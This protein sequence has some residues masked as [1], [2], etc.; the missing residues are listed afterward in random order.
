MF[1]V[2]FV[3]ILL[4]LR[5]LH[6]TKPIILTRRKLP[7]TQ[8]RQESNR[9]DTSLFEQGK[10]IKYFVAEERSGRNRTLFLPPYP[11]PTENERKNKEK[12]KKHNVPPRLRPPQSLCHWHA[13][14]LR[15]CFL[16]ESSAFLT[17]E[18]IDALSPRGMLE[19][20]DRF[21][22]GQTDAKKAVAISLR[23]RWR[24]RQITDKGLQ[25]DIMPKN[26]LMIGPTGV[27][28]TEIS[29]RMA[30]ITDAPFIKVEATKYTEVGFK[31]KDVD[32]MIEDLFA[33]AKS[34]TRRRLERDRD[35]EAT[36]AAHDVLFTAY[37]RKQHFAAEAA[38]NA[39][40]NAAAGG[41]GA[42][43]TRP[44]AD[45]D[46]DDDDDDDD[47][48]PRPTAAAAKPADGTPAAPP[49]MTFDQFV[50][51]LTAG[52]LD[53]E[54]VTIDITVAPPQPKAG[55]GGSPADLFGAMFMAGPQAKMVQQASHPIAEALP[56]AKRE[57]L[58]KLIDDASVA[59]AAKTLCEQEGIIFLDEID[60]VVSDTNAS[61]SDVSSMG[62][63]Q[64]LLPLIEGSTVT[65]KDGTAIDTSCILFI[66]SGAF[67]VAKPSDMIAE[68]QGRLP[69]RVE[70][71]PL[72]E[73]EF[74][75]ILVEPKFNLLA[76]QR[77]LMKTEGV[78]LEFS[79]D[80]I[81]ALARV[82]QKVNASAQNIGARRLHTIL[83]M[84]MDEHSFDFEPHVGKK[85]IIDDAYVTEKTKALTV[86]VDLSKY[87][88]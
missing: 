38:A 29:R 28:K 48:A 50:A 20:L 73:K 82:S 72:N 71:Q 83:E 18:E 88:L 77:A 70:L 65:L 84:V 24:R 27:G 78:D 21:I 75:R 47:D 32:S 62:V 4:V 8:L 44:A 30:R 11:D 26:I 76:Q 16:P 2:D 31:G 87:I 13:G 69:V 68:L 53:T 57:A 19:I 34:K 51:K 17:K 46:D 39:A 7:I 12:K 3:R 42:K 6:R 33:S 45:E 86:N 14:R 36:K 56:L 58:N 25:A 15:L 74:R 80:G 10:R 60:K 61:A 37:M 9:V 22:V 64:D 41:S 49:K 79:D 67:H 35:E 59:A 55:G 5:N 52:E 23:N 54:V 81:G 85:V 43:P 40:A 63:Q 66:C 1:G